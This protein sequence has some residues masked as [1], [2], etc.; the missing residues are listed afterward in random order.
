[1]IG[2]GRLISIIIPAS[3]EESYL[4][5]CLQ[6]L[7]DSEPPDFDL[8][9]VVVSNGSRDRT[10][11][12]ARGFGPLFA[13]QGWSLSV[14]ELEEGGKINALN[15]GDQA[16]KGELRVYMDAD[17]IASPR[18][19]AGLTRALD[20]QDAAYASGR[21]VPPPARNLAL[22]AYV[23]FWTRLPFMTEGVPGCGLLAVN[24][25]GRAR[26]GEWPAIIAD[27]HFAKLSFAPHERHLVPETYIFPMATSFPGLVRARR[28]Q[29]RGVSEI[30][31][32]FPNIV[33]NEGKVPMGIK[34]IAALFLRDPL[35]FLVYA[36]V[37]LAVRSGRWD[38]TWSRSR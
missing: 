36:G 37:T 28:R 30:A 8:E 5:S 2:A 15:A 19:L 27:D 3:N 9:V 1:M 35:G 11:G 6:S 4:P 17:T 13:A 24:A 14:L 26:W 33:V 20:R 25:A 18:L 10:A 23:R 32:I 21:P 29:D 38:G 34:R 22:R 12:V 16:A 7:L 31:T